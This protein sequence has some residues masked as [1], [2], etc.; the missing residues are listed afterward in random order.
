MMGTTFELDFQEVIAFMG[1]FRCDFINAQGELI[2]DRKTNTY[3]T[4]TNCKTIEDLEAKVLMAVSATL[5]NG[6]RKLNYLLKNFNHYFETTLTFKDMEVIYTNLCYSNKFEENKLFIS[7]GFP[8][9]ELVQ[10]AF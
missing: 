10:E 4:F 2:I 3:T 9:E 6:Q 8:M 1:A 7:K 5:S